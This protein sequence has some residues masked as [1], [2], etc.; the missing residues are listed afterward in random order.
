VD[1]RAFPFPIPHSQLPPLGSRSRFPVPGSRFPVPGSPSL[2]PLFLEIVDS[3]RCPRPHDDTW[4]VAAVDRYEGRFIFEGVLGC[5]I[6]HATYPVRHGVTWFTE[7]EDV[8]SVE[9]PAT[10]MV[11]EGDDAV[12]RAAALLDLGEPSGIVLLGGAQ[13]RLVHALEEITQAN[14]LLLD[15]TAEVS[16][17]AGLSVLRGGGVVPLAVGS[18]RAA[19]LDAASA[20]PAHLDGVTRALR[21]GGRLVAPAS[22]PVPAG[23]AELARDG[24]QW[25]GAKEPGA[26]APVALGRRR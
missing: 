12:M 4:L 2:S 10:G 20:S 18:V 3:L 9:P 7:P 13:G 11:V 21:T 22:V 24:A 25:V 23:I 17:G 1:T 8:E 16:L 5:P 15:P 6:C 19:L 14:F 26:S